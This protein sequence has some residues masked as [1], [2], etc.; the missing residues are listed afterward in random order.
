M[1]G[2]IRTSISRLICPSVRNPFFG[3]G[4][5]GGR[6]P[7]EHMGNLYVRTYIPSPGLS[8]P[9][10]GLN[11]PLRALNQPLGGLSQALGGLSLSLEGLNQPLRGLTQALGGLSQAPGGLRQ[12]LGSLSQPLE[13]LSQHIHI[14]QKAQPSIK[15]VLTKPLRRLIGPSGC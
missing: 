13:G 1:K 9:E 7:V 14:F 8:L 12:P 3:F 10:G 11:Q 6:S 4:P 5:K 2:S 15:G